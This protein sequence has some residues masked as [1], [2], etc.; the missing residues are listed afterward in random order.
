MDFVLPMLGYV[1]FVVTG[2]LASII[3][4]WF[5]CRRLSPGSS[6]A[7]RVYMLI[8]G[9]VVALVAGKLCL[10]IGIWLIMLWAQGIDDMSAAGL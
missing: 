8:L 2:V 6:M 7:R 9:P 5:L 4:L 10:F 3:F 1:C